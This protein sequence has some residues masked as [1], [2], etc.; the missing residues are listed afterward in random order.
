MNAK[1]SR[2]ELQA[3]LQ[4]QLEEIEYKLKKLAIYENPSISQFVASDRAAEAI[5]KIQILVNQLQ[6]AK[7]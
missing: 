1:M 7:S 6:A 3:E 5:S 2:F 4:Y